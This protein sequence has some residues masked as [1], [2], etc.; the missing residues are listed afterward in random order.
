MD[1]LFV[2]FSLFF[3]FF[4]DF[5]LYFSPVLQFFRELFTFSATKL[6]LQIA[7]IAYFLQ[8]QPLL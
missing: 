1:N 4:T 5:I 8:S 7:E 6:G 2:H 3:I